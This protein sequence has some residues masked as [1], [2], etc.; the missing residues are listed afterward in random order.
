[1][2][3]NQYQR[4]SDSTESKKAD[5]VTKINE[6]HYRVLNVREDESFECPKCKSKGQ[7]TMIS[8]DDETEEVY[9]ILGTKVKHDDLVG[10]TVA[11]NKCG[12]EIEILGSHNPQQSNQN[13]KKGAR[14]RE[15]N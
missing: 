4:K 6:N 10:V 9:K 11:C 13:Y 2:N 1:M 3:A 15:K 14:Y 5:Y 7:R 8:P 12:A